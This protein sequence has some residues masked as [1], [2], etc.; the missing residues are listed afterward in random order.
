VVTPP[1]AGVAL[2]PPTIRP[3]ILILKSVQVYSAPIN[4]QDNP[5]A[6]PGAV[7]LYTVLATNRASVIDTGIVVITDP[8]PANTEVFV[9][10][11]N[12]VGSGPLVFA[13]GS[14]AQPR[15]HDSCQHNGLSYNYTPIPNVDGY[16]SAA[17]DIKVFLSG[18]FHASNGVPHPSFSITFW[19]R[20]Q[21]TAA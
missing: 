16:D 7:M 12:G 13:D 19:V 9:N 1:T 20:V 10:D 14:Q 5:K 3:D 18:P 4:L 17:T 8:M 2:F 15:L 11:I 21:Y 6:I